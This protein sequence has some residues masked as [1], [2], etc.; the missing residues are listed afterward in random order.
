[1]DPHGDL[2]EREPNRRAGVASAGPGPGAWVSVLQTRHSCCVLADDCGHTA[3]TD[4]G[5]AVNASKETS[6]QIQN[7]GRSQ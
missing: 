6:S 3:S 5:A 4:G 7:L 2:T 1:M